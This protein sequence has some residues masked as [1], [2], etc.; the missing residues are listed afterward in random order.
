M[1]G[2][3]TLL[4]AAIAVPVLAS[5]ELPRAVAG[6]G[7]LQGP[8]PASS[9]PDVS[10]NKLGMRFVAVP[11]GTFDMGSTIGPGEAPVYR[12]WASASSACP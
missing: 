1:I 7:P 9:A 6:R 5:G 11:G 12:A 3:R 10:R 2:E 4:A 8:P